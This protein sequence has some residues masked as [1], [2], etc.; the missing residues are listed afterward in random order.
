MKWL[1][2]LLGKST[3]PTGPVQTYVVPVGRQYAN[4]VALNAVGLDI[5]HWAMTDA[6]VGIIV[7]CDIDGM[8]DVTLVKP[9]GTTKMTLNDWDQPMPMTVR[10]QLSEIRRAYLDE[11]PA[12]RH[13]D[14]NH[15]AHMRLHGYR[16]SSETAQ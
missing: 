12:A 16:H 4:R 1:D 2:K 7:G 3:A 11:V 14:R 10:K 5:R 15:E 8:V 9:D 6:G 13:P